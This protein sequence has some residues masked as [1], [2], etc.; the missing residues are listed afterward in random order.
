[1][2]DVGSTASLGQK[3][4]GKDGGAV[5]DGGSSHSQRSGRKGDAGRGPEVDGMPWTHVATL[6][7]QIQEDRRGAVA[8]ERQLVARNRATGPGKL[9]NGRVAQS[10]QLS[11]SR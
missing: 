7:H 8:E 3:S 1:M 2:C 6:E 10:L 11:L 5:E 9:D 4:N